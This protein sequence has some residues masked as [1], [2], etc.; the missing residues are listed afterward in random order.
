[1]PVSKP[2]KHIAYEIKIVHVI[3]GDIQY[4]LQQNFPFMHGLCE[5]P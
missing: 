2:A 5:R 4:L 1:M 3:R